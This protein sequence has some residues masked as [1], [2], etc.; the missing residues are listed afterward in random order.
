MTNGNNVEKQSKKNKKRGITNIVSGLIM[1][2]FA[3]IAPDLL[4]PIVKMPLD[5]LIM[6]ADGMLFLGFIQIIIGIIMLISA[7]KKQNEYCPQCGKKVRRTRTFLE[8]T[9]GRTGNWYGNADNM[10]RDTPYSCRYQMTW[11]CKCGWAQEKYIKKSAG[12]YVLFQNGDFLDYV[13]DPLPDFD[14]GFEE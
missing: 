5:Q 3:I 4:A 9:A 11:E 8:R 13:Q 14:T 2:A 12:K 6:L 10:H 7:R 1:I